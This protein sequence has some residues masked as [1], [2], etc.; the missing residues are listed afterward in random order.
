MEYIFDIDLSH[1]DGGSQQFLMSSSSDNCL[2]VYDTESLEVIS[3]ISAHKKTINRIEFSRVSPF[4]LYSCSSDNSLCL[5]DTR[6]PSTA[7]FSIKVL[8]PYIIQ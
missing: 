1:A 7:C 3:T 6:A 8:L 4:L 2:R 5:W